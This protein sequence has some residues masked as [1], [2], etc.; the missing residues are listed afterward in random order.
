MHKSR[1]IA[2]I[3]FLLG[4]SQDSLSPDS[5]APT[6]S[7]TTMSDQE[8]EIVVGG[9]YATKNNDGSYRVMKVLVVDDFAVHLR[10]YANRFEE[11]PS[12]IDSS[13][14]T[15]GSIADDRGFGIG[16]F[17]WDKKGFWNDDPVFLKKTSVADDELEGYRLYL[18]AMGGSQ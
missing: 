2:L 9:L 8:H 1:S 16:H 10:S 12:D 14:L 5:T 6:N 4:C 17:P 15:L 3:L 11:L 13:I 7:T 18:D